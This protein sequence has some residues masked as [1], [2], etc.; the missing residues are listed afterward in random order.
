MGRRNEHLHL[1]RQ[2][3][4]DDAFQRRHARNYYV[5]GRQ[6][7]DDG[8]LKEAHRL[9]KRALRYDAEMAPAL[10]TLAGVEFNMGNL[11]NARQYLARAQALAPDDPDTWFLAGNVAFCEN[12]PEAALSA[13]QRARQLGAQGPELQYNFGLTYLALGKAAEAQRLFL[14]LLKEQPQHAR[15]WDALGCARRLLKDREGA[16]TAFLKA[17]DLEHGLNDARDHLAQLL[18]E[19]NNP[20]YAQ[21]ILEEALELDPGRHSSLHLLGAAHAT[22]GNFADAVAA[23]EK[24]ILLG[25]PL[26]ETYHLLA[27]AYLHL[28]RRS[29][30]IHTLERLL[31]LY[32]DHVSGHLQ[33]SLLLLESGDYARGW[34]HLDRAQALEPD[35][36]AVR[37]TLTA[38]QALAPRP[39]SCAD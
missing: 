5:M 37:Y 22:I 35:N 18:L 31:E 2:A 8:L 16:T 9:L 17:L 39:D 24:L 38:A 34:R 23:W 36:S 25:D 4:R 28:Q 1:Y 10:R 13:Y 6:L 12:N 11:P 27:N 7:A 3:G 30:A 14:A 29:E 21:R 32:P 26:P 19:M 15:G 20:H 33:L